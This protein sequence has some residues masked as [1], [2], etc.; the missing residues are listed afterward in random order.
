MDF[1]AVIL[2]RHSVSLYIPLYLSHSLAPLYLWFGLPEKP[3]LEFFLF[4]AQNNLFFNQ[5]SA[6]SIFKTMS[7]YGFLLNKR[8]SL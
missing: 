6:L 4:N 3:F 7:Y 5:I 2:A 1:L 8:S